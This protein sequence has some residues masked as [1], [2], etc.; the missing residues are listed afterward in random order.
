M[1]RPFWSL[2]FWLG[3]ATTYALGLLV[4]LGLLLWP[5]S[6][7]LAAVGDPLLAG[8]TNEVVDRVT[9][10]AASLA[11]PVLRLTNQGTGPALDL[12][13]KTGVPPMKI[14]SGAK[15]A[16][17]NADL[18]DGKDATAFLRGYEIVNVQTALDSSSPKETYA[19]CPLGK[20]VVGGGNSLL[21]EAGKVVVTRSLPTSSAEGWVAT[22]I[23]TGAGTS[24]SWRLS[25]RAVCAN[26]GP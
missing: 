4:L 23:E 8:R 1:L 10:L 18:L 5:V 19:V 12:R 22:A 7:G 26:T 3:R 24:G 25:V 14:N 20:R 9:A 2:V 13:V 21:N 6:F 16:Q 11:G 17:L 15:V